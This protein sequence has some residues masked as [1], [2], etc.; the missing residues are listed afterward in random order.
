MIVGTFESVRLL[1]L[2]NKRG[3]NVRTQVHAFNKE[4]RKEPPPP[5]EPARKLTQKNR[6]LRISRTFTCNID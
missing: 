2:I 1:L 3:R 5:Q 4:I 6:L